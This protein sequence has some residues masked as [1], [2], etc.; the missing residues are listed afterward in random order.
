MPLPELKKL[1]CSPGEVVHL[2]SRDGSAGSEM[3]RKTT[4][5]KARSQRG[6]SSDSPGTRADQPDST[7]L[8]FW[9]IPVSH[10]DETL[11]ADFPAA[12]SRHSRSHD[13]FRN[14]GVFLGFP[15]LPEIPPFPQFRTGL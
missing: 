7:Q 13:H 10:V 11:K 9:V 14:G 4:V 2:S 6:F 15:A 1:K 3:A 5:S 12:L 8:L